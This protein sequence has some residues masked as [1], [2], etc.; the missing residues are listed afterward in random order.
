MSDTDLVKPYREYF[1]ILYANT[2]ELRRRA[3]QLRYQVYCQELGWESPDRFPDGLEKDEF[4]DASLHCIL[5]HRP[6]GIDAGTVRLVA[7]RPDSPEPCLP[8]TAHYDSRLYDSEHSPLMMPKG[9]YGEISRLAL[10][11]RFRRRPGERNTPD[12]GPEVFQWTQTDR[13]R[14]PHIALGLYLA[15]ATVGLSHGLSAVYA[16]MEPRL[17]RHLHYGGIFFEQIGQVV[18]F[19]GARAPF[20]LSR[21]MLFEHLGAPLRALLDAI[22]EDLGVGLS[23]P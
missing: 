21:S 9:I 11:E 10:S 13:R 12:G 2:D 22:A 7:T 18:E 23:D 19:R 16:M 5:V 15:A 3:Y 6:S 1:Q 17:A 8:L 20:Y 14:F 4:D